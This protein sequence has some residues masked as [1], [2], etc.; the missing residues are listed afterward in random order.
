MNRSDWQESAANNPIER[1]AGRMPVPLLVIISLDPQQHAVSAFKKAAS[2]RT[3][4]TILFDF[5][6][7]SVNVKNKILLQFDIDTAGPKSYALNRNPM[8]TIKK[9]PA[10]G[11]T[12]QE[13]KP[14]LEIVLKCDSVGS[15]EAVTKS[16][17]ALTTPN[18]EIT[19]IHSGVGAI[20]KSDVLFAVTASGLIVGFQ[21]A[22]MPAMDIVLREHKVEV[23]LYDVIYKLTDDIQAIAGDMVPH[24]PEEQIIGSG[25]IIALFKSTRKGIIIGC[26]IQEGFFAVGERFRIISAM[27]PV[28]EGAIESL[29]IG[30]AT[31]NK[32]TPGKHVGIRIKDFN[33]AKIGDLVESFRPPPQVNAPLWEPTGR[34]IRK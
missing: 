17:T 8:K 6:F 1:L 26:Q 23:R 31:V 18:V 19:V 13:K 29:H 25:K 34:I 9:L 3:V 21:V 24:P 4:Y 33:K 12:A 20:S 10:P 7:H 2:R 30:N 27:G 15:V 11:L 5:L 22:V 32:V 16:I 14:K 28:Y